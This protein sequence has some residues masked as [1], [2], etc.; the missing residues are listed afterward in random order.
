MRPA[1]AATGGMPGANVR[2]LP[3]PELGRNVLGLAPSEATSH[4]S[5]YE[6]VTR[7]S[8]RLAILCLHIS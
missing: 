5:R 7:Q 2:H 4:G 6:T 1:T 8:L 3:E